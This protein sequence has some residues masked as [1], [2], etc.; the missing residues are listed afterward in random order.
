MTI[1]WWTLGIQAVNV[2]VL[3]WLLGHFFWRPVAAM[4]EQ[5]RAAAELALADA[6]ARQ[7]EASAALADN[8]RTRAG[9]AVERETLL[10]DARAAAEEERVHLTAMAADEALAIAAR[11][12]S[13]MERDA[14]AVDAAWRQKAISL[15]VDIARRLCAPLSG[16]A[17]QES[18]IKRLSEQLASLPEAQRRALSAVGGGLEAISATALNAAEQ[19]DCR[20]RIVDA[21]GFDSSIVFS[22]QPELLAG[23][24]LRSP[25]LVVGNS[26]RAD[27][28]RID[29]ELARVDAA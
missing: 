28:R 18:F 10:R 11:A 8:E 22:T 13:D 23:V 19:A 4:I 14:L 12:G 5:R 27:L 6:A 16:A 2:S 21:L 17:L 29:R 24:E 26:W 9:F 3:V 7:T 15:A 1:D 25:H 20:R